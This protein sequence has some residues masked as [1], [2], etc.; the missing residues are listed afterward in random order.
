MQMNPVMMCV[1]VD[2]LRMVHDPVMLS[3]AVGDVV[4]EGVVD[5]SVA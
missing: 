4:A 3:Q 2:D 1:V 5:E